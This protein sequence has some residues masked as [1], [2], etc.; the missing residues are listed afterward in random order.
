MLNLS[1]V[2]PKY[3]TRNQL[4]KMWW[5]CLDANQDWFITVVLKLNFSG[6]FFFNKKREWQ[7]E[8]Y[9]G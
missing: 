8:C 4:D 2:G 6:S 5:A 7:A 9:P 1:Q 3:I